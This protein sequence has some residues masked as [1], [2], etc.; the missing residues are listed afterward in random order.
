M[1][2]SL[3]CPKTLAPSRTRGA[4][5]APL[6]SLRR[7]LPTALRSEP[8]CAF[9]IELSLPLVFQLPTVGDLAEAVAVLQQQIGRDEDRLADMLRRLEGLANEEI[10]LMLGSK[11]GMSR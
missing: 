9:A 3:R 6:S 11:T 10:S 5:R 8:R 4:R 1:R 2:A 7:C